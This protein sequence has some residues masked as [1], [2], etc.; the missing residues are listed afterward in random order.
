MILLDAHHSQGFSD[1]KFECSDIKSGTLDINSAL[2]RKVDGI[3]GPPTERVSDHHDRPLTTWFAPGMRGGSDPAPYNGTAPGGLS[4]PFCL[5]E[6]RIRAGLTSAQ[7][8]LRFLLKKCLTNAATCYMLRASA[9][10]TLGAKGLMYEPT[11]VG[12]Q[13]HNPHRETEIGG[14]HMSRKHSTALGIGAAMGGAAVRRVPQHGHRPRR[15]FIGSGR[16][17]RPVRFQWPASRR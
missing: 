13:P 17:E 3:G 8:R 1:K 2:R 5:V 11:A 7:L 4:D 14:S 9:A 16:V 15:R 10:Q 6:L 12:R